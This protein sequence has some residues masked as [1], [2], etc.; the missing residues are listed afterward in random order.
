MSSVCTEIQWWSECVHSFTNLS[1]LLLFYC[2]EE[3]LLS[4]VCHVGFICTVTHTHT[5]AHLAGTIQVLL[6]LC[7]VVKREEGVSVAGGAVTDAVTLPQQPSL[8]DHLSTLHSV[9][10]VLLILKDLENKTTHWSQSHN[11]Q[12]SASL[13]Q[14]HLIMMTNHTYY[15]LITVITSLQSNAMIAGLQTVP[16]VCL[17]S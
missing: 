5:H 13:L 7:D 12:L 2:S 11:Q 14:T 4:T 10:Q 8:P 3:N 16:G 9:S 17:L 6:V 15:V 1:V